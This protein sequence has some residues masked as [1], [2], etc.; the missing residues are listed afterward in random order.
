MKHQTSSIVYKLLNDLKSQYKIEYFSP[1][2]DDRDKVI[3]TIDK[4]SNSTIDVIYEK[5]IRLTI[6]EPNLKT[7]LMTY[8]SFFHSYS[9]YQFK[10]YLQVKSHVSPV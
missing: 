3:E 7:Y 6:L 5:F 9:H 8:I 4:S 1:N 2:F 10:L